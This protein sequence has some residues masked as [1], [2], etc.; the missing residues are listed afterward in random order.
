MLNRQALELSYQ[1]MRCFIYPPKDYV[2]E[3]QSLLLIQYV[4]LSPIQLMMTFTPRLTSSQKETAKLQDGEP[5]V[6]HDNPWWHILRNLGLSLT[7]IEQ[8]PLN[9]NAL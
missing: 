7:A 5:A 4:S 2:E 9:L 8:A 6:V 1:R 3:M